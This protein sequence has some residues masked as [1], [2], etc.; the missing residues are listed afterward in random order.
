MQHRGT[1]QVATGL[2]RVLLERRAL[3]ESESLLR[4]QLEVL[5]DAT[6]PGSIN[7]RCLLA[8]VLQARGEP[9][10]AEAVF[11]EIFELTS[12]RYPDSHWRR[13]LVEG[14][15]GLFLLEEGR[16]EEAEAQLIPAVRRLIDEPGIERPLVRELLRGAVDLYGRWGRPHRAAEYEGLLDI[17]GSR[18]PA[19]TAST[20]PQRQP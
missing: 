16:F 14:R 10:A 20:S 17:E 9:D 7:A 18:T 1:R 3:D 15:Y 19:E 13:A 4:D 12:V 11:D 6:N 5:P 2:A 8:R